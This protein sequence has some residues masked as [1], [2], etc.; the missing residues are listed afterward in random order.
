[1][2]HVGNLI[3]YWIPPESGILIYCTTVQRITNLKKKTEDYTQQMNNFQIKL[4]GKWTTTSSDIL[5]QYRDGPRNNVLS[6]EY[7]D[8]EFVTKF[9]PVINHEDVK[10]ADDDNINKI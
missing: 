9:K 3:S 10:D 1:M 8:K 7:E 4:E 2:H 5:G 6:L